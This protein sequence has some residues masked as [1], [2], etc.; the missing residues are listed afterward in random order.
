MIIS[1][2]ML[3]INRKLLKYNILAND[4]FDFYAVA[5]ERRHVRG[6]EVI[7]ACGVKLYAKY[8]EAVFRLAGNKFY[9]RRDVDGLFARLRALDDLHFAA[10]RTFKLARGDIGFKHKTPYCAL[11]CKLSVGNLD[12]NDIEPRECGRL[13]LFLY[14][15][16]VDILGHTEIAK[17]PF[18]FLIDRKRK[19]D[20]KTGMGIKALAVGNGKT[21]SYEHSVDRT[22]KVEMGD[23][24]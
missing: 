9:H 6:I 24:F 12:R 4:S 17:L 22:L 15:L 11:C 16:H 1:N 8:H 13:K 20:I 18:A 2:N 19:R 7:V 21:A 5:E 10:K 14:S 23:I 3:N